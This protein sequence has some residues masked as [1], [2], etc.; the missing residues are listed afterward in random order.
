MLTFVNFLKMERIVFPGSIY[1]RSKLGDGYSGDMAN[2][3]YEKHLDR[4][5]IT[6]DGKLRNE[7]EHKAPLKKMEED[8]KKVKEKNRVINVKYESE[9]AEKASRERAEKRCELENEAPRP[10]V[11]RQNK[12]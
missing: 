12:W 7:I 2:D 4:K 10:P 1:W 5:T 9:F 3:F 11:R 6:E 8:S